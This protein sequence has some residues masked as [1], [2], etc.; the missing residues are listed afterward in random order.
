MMAANFLRL[1]K[2]D[3]TLCIVESDSERELKLQLRGYIRKKPHV[4]ESNNEDSKPPDDEQDEEES[5]SGDLIEI[6]NH[7]FRVLR[8]TD[9]LIFANSRRLVETLADLLR[10]H[11]ERN[12]VPVEFFPHHGSLSKEI[13]EE[14]EDFIKDTTRPGNI[15]CT[16]TLELGIDIGSVNSIA[17]IGSPPSVA[18]MRQRLGRSGRRKGESS[19]LRV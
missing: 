9:N 19:I 14:A 15:V 12:H 11:C 8:G 18:S 7:L 4:A 6:S 13:R 17:Q 3:K 1:G 16:S 5:A 2:G 10:R